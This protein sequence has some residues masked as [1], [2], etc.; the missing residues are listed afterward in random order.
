L[1][2][3]NDTPMAFRLELWIAAAMAR[4]LK[5]VRGDRTALRHAP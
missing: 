1:R 4:C 3:A 5:E 2:L